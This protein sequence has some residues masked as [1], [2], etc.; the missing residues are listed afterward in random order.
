[1]RKH[2]GSL[3]FIVAGIAC[4][5]TTDIGD[6]SDGGSSPGGSSQGGSSHAGK[7]SGGSSSAGKST[8]GSISMGGRENGGAAG[9]GFGGTINIG[10]T[11]SVGGTI[12]IGGVG[13]TGVIDP[14]CPDVIPSGAC[15]DAGLKCQYD[16]SGCLCYP[17]GTFGYCPRVD[18]TCVGGP[19]PAAAPPPD[20]GAGGFTTKLAV[21]PPARICTCSADVWACNYGF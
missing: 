19:V 13:G 16:F 10:G 1:M 9:I 12:S 7:D 15:E 14:R 3:V 4:G 5:G 11:I 18:T 6:E 20:P 21:A 8:G 17:Q 2:L